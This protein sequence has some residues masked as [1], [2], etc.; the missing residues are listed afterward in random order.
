ML[1]L[2]RSRGI[3]LQNQIPNKN[4]KA[5]QSNDNLPLSCQSFGEI[6]GSLFGELQVKSF[7]ILKGFR[8]GEDGPCLVRQQCQGIERGEQV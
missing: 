8:T 2:Q 1:H 4:K 5:F 7:N 6:R 3:P